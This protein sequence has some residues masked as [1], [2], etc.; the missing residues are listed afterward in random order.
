MESASLIFNSFK[1]MRY[2][3]TVTVFVMGINCTFGL[4]GSLSKPYWS[5]KCHH[6]Y[7]IHMLVQICL[8]RT[9]QMEIHYSQMQSRPQI[10]MLM[11]NFGA[12]AEMLLLL[13][14]PTNLS[15][16]K[17][18]AC[19]IFHICC[20]SNNSTYYILGLYAHDK[21]A[22]APPQC[23]AFYQCNQ[24]LMSTTKQC[25]GVSDYMV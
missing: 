24:E 25:K 20:S 5:I 4:L 15:C 16:Y 3:C 13:E 8:C 10:L 1:F 2:M 21:R 19:V 6:L 22:Q 14:W 11:W 12:C 9:K 7:C 23:I 17:V 18:S